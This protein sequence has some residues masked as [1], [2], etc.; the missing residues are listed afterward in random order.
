MLARSCSYSIHPESHLAN[1]QHQNRRD[2][3]K[4]QLALFF[5]GEVSL[6]CIH[7]WYQ[8]NCSKQLHMSE[9]TY[10][11]VKSVN[12]LTLWYPT[13]GHSDPSLRVHVKSLLC[14]EVILPVSAYLPG[15]L[16]ATDFHHKAGLVRRIPVSMKRR[17][18]T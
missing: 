13:W 2:R 5:L 7:S 15:L 16:Q 14:S 10:V 17:L 12:K 3:P 6:G 11:R 18:P 8:S 9:C 4:L 1:V